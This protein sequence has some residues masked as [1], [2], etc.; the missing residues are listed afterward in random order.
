MKIRV[1]GGSG[2]E[3]PGFCL[4]GF[5]INGRVVLDAGTV[6]SALSP[7][8]LSRISHVV[9]SH[10]HFD[11]TRGIPFLADNLLGLTGG[12]LYIAGASEALT[13][14]KEHMFNNQCWPDF[15][16]I[17]S[18][19]EPAVRLRKLTPGREYVI[20][21]ISFK[22]VRVNHTVPTTGYIIRENGKAIAYSG[23]TQATE[24]IWKAASRLGG[25]LKAVLAETSYPDRMQ[26]MAEKTGHLTPRTLAME[27]GKLKGFDG[28]V[29]VY[30]VKSRFRAEIERDLKA[31]GRKKVVVVHDGMEIAI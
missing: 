14:I 20:D 29:Y 21:G 18:V 28:P 6:S 25:E 22:P 9:L 7:K 27:L 24:A 10:A 26:E 31:L 23:D 1:L 12:P 11:H 4:T 16:R 2:S 30:H 17:P 3:Q 13:A 15:T 8:E 19:K 5:L